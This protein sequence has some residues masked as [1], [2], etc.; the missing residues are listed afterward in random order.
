[1]LSFR[2][3]QRID[4][5]KQLA[6]DYALQRT[7]NF[8]QREIEA[9][10]HRIERTN[11]NDPNHTINKLRLLWLQAELAALTDYG[12][13]RSDY[14]VLL[15]KARPISRLINRAVVPGTAVTIDQQIKRARDMLASQREAISHYRQKTATLSGEESD[16]AHTQ[17][18]ATLGNVEQNSSA[19]VA[20]I[21]RLEQELARLQQKLDAT[22][23]RA[24]GISDTPADFL[25]ISTP[26]QAV[27]TD[28]AQELLQQSEDAYR[29][30]MVEMVR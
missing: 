15:N 13:R 4:E 9:M 30:S 22:E 14:D 18:H 25:I 19:L 26:N 8:L 23:Q 21:A 11:A 17:F 29:Q 6:H 24:A 16:S 10:R 28:A 2:N 12:K 5:L 3:R 20:T 1:A 7:D 27:K